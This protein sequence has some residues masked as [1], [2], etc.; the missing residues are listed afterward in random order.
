MKNGGLL[1]AVFVSCRETVSARH[2]ITHRPLE[3]VR[4]SSDF[5]RITNVPMRLGTCPTGTIATTFLASISIA[6]TDIAA[7]FEM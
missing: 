3:H 7:A 5:Q 4:R 6:V 1:A 2:S